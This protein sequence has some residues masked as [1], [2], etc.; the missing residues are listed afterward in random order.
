MATKAY[1]RIGDC[2]CFF[3]KLSAKA[4]EQSSGMIVSTAYV[5]GERYIFAFRPDQVDD[6]CNLLGTFAANE[7]LNLDWDTATAIAAAVRISCG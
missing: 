2:P 5:R 1:D 7:E 6:V 4:A 3:C